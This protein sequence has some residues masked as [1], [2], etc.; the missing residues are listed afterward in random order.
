[1][2]QAR[3][4]SGGTV[5]RRLRHHQQPLP[6]QRSGQRA[7]THQHVERLESESAGTAAPPVPGV[8]SHRRYATSGAEFVSVKTARL[9]SVPEKSMAAL[10]PPPRSSA[11]DERAWRFESEAI[12][13]VSHFFGLRTQSRTN[14]SHKPI[15]VVGLLAQTLAARGGQFIKLGA[16]IVFRCAPTCLEQA[17]AHKPKQTWIKSALLDEQ[18]IL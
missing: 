13:G 3:R 12:R 18:C 14:G 8:G 11:N 1:M 6:R 16:A 4:K 9:K 10:P 15:P 17:L 2:G 7:R 5:A